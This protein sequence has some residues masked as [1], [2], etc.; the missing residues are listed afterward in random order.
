MSRQ[1]INTLFQFYQHNQDVRIVAK[2]T[3]NNVYFTFQKM[4]KSNHK[5]IL[6]FPELT[7]DK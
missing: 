3:E 2:E 6:K 4:K 7:L 5:N 1:F